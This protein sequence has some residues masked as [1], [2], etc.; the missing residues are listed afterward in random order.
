MKKLFII[1]GIIE[2]TISALIA[3]GI[4]YVLDLI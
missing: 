4:V 2:A 1:R 3:G